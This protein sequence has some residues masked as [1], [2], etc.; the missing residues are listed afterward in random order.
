MVDASLAIVATSEIYDSDFHTNLCLND[1][2]CYPALVK[3]VLGDDVFRAFANKVIVLGEY[4][5][6]PNRFIKWG[7]QIN[8]TQWLAHGIIH[9]L[10]YQHHGFRDANPLGGHPMWKWEGYAEYHSIG[11]EW[12]FEELL[13]IY[14]NATGDDFQL[15]KLEDDYTT[16]KLHIKYLLMTKY[17]LEVLHL[18]Y[19]TFMNYEIEEQAL[20]ELVIREIQK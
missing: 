6:Q 8:F 7:E 18:D 1:G 4:S 12:S 3:T 16:I 17:C 10:Q 19:E 9:N 15:V 13:A 5:A 20:L 2:S 11:E 14:E